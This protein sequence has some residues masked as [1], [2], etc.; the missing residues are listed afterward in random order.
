[1]AHKTRK[2]RTG[3]KMTPGYLVTH[4]SDERIREVC[5]TRSPAQLER[6]A[7]EREEDERTTALL[8][9]HREE[10]AR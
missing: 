3:C 10:A 9:R 8:R 4:E 6:E 2:N 5:R 7:R 1:M